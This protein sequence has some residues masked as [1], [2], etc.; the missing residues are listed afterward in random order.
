[1]YILKQHVSS[2]LSMVISGIQVRSS[3]LTV[4]LTYLF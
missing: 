2:F 3:E 1:M 4:A